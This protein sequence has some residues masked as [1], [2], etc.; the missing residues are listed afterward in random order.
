MTKEYIKHA[1][2]KRSD[3]IISIGK[4]HADIIKKCPFGTCKNL[5]IQGFVTNTNRFVDR[6]EAAKIAFKAKQIK[7]YKRGQILLSEEIWF[8]G[9]YEYDE[10]KGYFLPEFK[11]F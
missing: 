11:L 8:Y 3:N 1:A 5:S 2:I 7:E 9:D 4:N 6:K 10:K